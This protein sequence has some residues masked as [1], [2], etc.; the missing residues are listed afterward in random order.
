M[1]LT[2]KT[3]MMSSKEIAELASKEHKHVIRDIWNMLEQ[4]YGIES[5]SPN[6]D[7]N[8]FKGILVNKGIMRGRN[9]VLDI[10]LDR[11]HTE[12]LITGYDVKRRA[13]VI[14]RWHEIDE[15]SSY[16]K[17]DKYEE[18]SKSHLIVSMDSL[19][20]S[21]LVESRHDS[22]KRTIERLS[23]SGVIRLPPMVVCGKINNLGFEQQTKTYK[24]EGEQ[25]KRDSIIV[26]AQ[27]S[28]EFTARLVDRWLELERSV[29]TP[30]PQIQAGYSNALSHGQFKDALTLLESSCGTLDLSLS[31][32]LLAYRNLQNA[33]GLP[34]LFAGVKIEGVIEPEPVKVNPTPPALIQPQIGKPATSSLKALLKSRNIDSP[35]NSVF[36]TLY[37]LDL[38]EKRFKESKIKNRAVNT[39]EGYWYLTDQGQYYGLNVSASRE[40]GETYPKF[41]DNRFSELLLKLGY[42]DG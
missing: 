41:Y 9:I 21:K 17:I 12:I 8:D 1:E 18:N 27:L 4:L 16:Q 10:K 42:I 29:R 14:D 15:C 24:F 20:I 39:K 35:S 38:V 26:V 31:D 40:R 3:A 22:V 23:Q 34:D 2:M 25:G 32:K 19:E 37:K 5:K 28:P 30:E 11:R 6:L 7:F 36:I 33:A 13:A